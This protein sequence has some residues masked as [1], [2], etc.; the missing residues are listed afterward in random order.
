MRKLLPEPSCQQLQLTQHSLQGCHTTGTRTLLYC[1]CMHQSALCSYRTPSNSAGAV[2][3]STSITAAAAAAAATIITVA[4]VAT[5]I[6]GAAQQHVASAD[7]LS[8]CE[9]K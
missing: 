1:H 7:R 3:L 6:C 9:R 2:V 8:V 5:V 4:P